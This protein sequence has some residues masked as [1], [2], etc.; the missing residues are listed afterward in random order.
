[1]TLTIRPDPNHPAGGYV[2]LS[3]PARPDLSGTVNLSVLE[4]F[5]S[6]WLA[7]SAEDAKG[8]IGVAAPNWQPIAHAFGPYPLRRAGDRVEFTVGPEIVNKID[9]YT[10]LV[11]TVGEADYSLSWPDDIM[12][13]AGAKG[14]GGL[15]VGRK[16]APVAELGPR[17]RQATPETS[18]EPP[19]AELPPPPNL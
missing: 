11:L 4:T 13:L 12:P 14:L 16:P 18:A 3:L 19:S 5:G 2:V 10:S 1:M 7:P 6:R 15:Q 8:G 9:G 17:L